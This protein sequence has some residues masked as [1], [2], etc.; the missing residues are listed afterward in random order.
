MN[1]CQFI[2]DDLRKKFSDLIIE[3]KQTPNV[4]TEL[5]ARFGYFTDGNFHS[6]L[7]D[8]SLYFN[9]KKHLDELCNKHSAS[10]SRIETHKIVDCNNLNI[11]KIQE[12]PGRTYYQKK[13]SDWSYDNKDWGIRFSRSSE[14]EIDQTKIINFTSNLKRDIYRTT[15]IDNRFNSQFFGFKIEISKVYTNKNCNYEIEL[16]SLY[17]AILT[18]DKWWGALKTLYG[19]SLNA[20]NNN[21]IISIKERILVS[22]DLNKLLNCNNHLILPSIVNRPKTLTSLKDIKN[23]AISIKIDGLHKIL[24]FCKTGTYSCSPSL[25]I[26]KINNLVSQKSTIIECEYI[27]STNKFF[28]FDIMIYN[29]N[30]IKNLYFKERYNLLYQFINNLNSETILCKDWYFPENQQNIYNIINNNKIP[31]DGLIFQSITYY[32]DDIF[33][34][35]SPENLTLDFYLQLSMNGTYEVYVSKFQRLHKIEIKIT[36]NIILLEDLHKKIVECKY[37]S[38]KNCWMPL[39]IRYDKLYPNSYEVVKSTIELLKDPITLDNIIN[40]L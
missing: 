17:G 15:Y 18:I 4:N 36:E 16:E 10:I 3:N 9:V 12:I 33:K 29:D 26:T 40:T 2:P 35:K 27:E 22:T 21:E 19:W 23:K 39:K 5:E 31:I 25:N 11:R 24:Y 37:I 8:N 13:I 34:W 14:K 20:K 1:V 38:E 32:T 6:K 7:L 28:A 30:N